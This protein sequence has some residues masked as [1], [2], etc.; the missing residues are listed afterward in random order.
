MIIRAAR[1]R[2]ST[3]ALRAHDPRAA[4]SQRAARK[5]EANTKP[6]RPLTFRISL[7]REPHHGAIQAESRSKAAGDETGPKAASHATES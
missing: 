4:G 7:T 3:V 1:V 5:K 6:E 2:R